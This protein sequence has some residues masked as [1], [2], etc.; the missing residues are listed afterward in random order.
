MH[1]SAS[2]LV[3]LLLI[4]DNTLSLYLAQFSA[5]QL[6]QIIEYVCVS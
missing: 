4:R 3:D 6:S 2:F 1:S 5:T